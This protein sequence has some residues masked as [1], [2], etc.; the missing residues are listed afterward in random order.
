MHFV[1]PPCMEPP[2]CFTAFWGRYEILMLQEDIA[3]RDDQDGVRPLGSW[4]QLKG[5]LKERY[6]EK[7]IV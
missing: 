3:Y 6:P 7:R 1:D 2:M 5:V 4:G